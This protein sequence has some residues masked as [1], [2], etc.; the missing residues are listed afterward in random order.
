MQNN[1]KCWEKLLLIRTWNWSYNAIQGWIAKFDCYLFVSICL[2]INLFIYLYSGF[3][4][5]GVLLQKMENPALSECLKVPVHEVHVQYVLINFKGSVILSFM[6]QTNK[7]Y[8]FLC[9]W[10]AMRQCDT[11]F[12]KF[13][14]GC[15]DFSIY[16]FFFVHFLRVSWSEKLNPLLRLMVFLR[17]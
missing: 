7:T 15:K 10:F 8:D 6:K 3:P 2:S 12:W 14:P 17:R 13:N 5:L 1:N 16:I 11:K 9:N 4:S